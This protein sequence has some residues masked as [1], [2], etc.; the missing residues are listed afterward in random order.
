M[1]VTGVEAY[2]RGVVTS[3]YT[4]KLNIYLPDGEHDFK[5]GDYSYHASV[6]GATTVATYEVGIRINGVDIGTESGTGWTYNGTEE[7][8]TLESGAAK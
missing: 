3:D 1:N 7:R 6:A 2:V 4:G 8:L 5:V